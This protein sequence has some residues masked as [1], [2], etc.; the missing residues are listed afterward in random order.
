M[1]VAE[2]VIGKCGRR[3]SKCRMLLKSLYEKPE[4]DAVLGTGEN[5]RLKDKEPI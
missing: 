4:G 5:L 3:N 2:G 1:V